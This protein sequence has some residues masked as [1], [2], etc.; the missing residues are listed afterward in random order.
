[1]ADVLVKLRIMPTGTDI[2]LNEVQKACETKIKSFGS[3]GMPSVK[4]EPIAFGL[5][6]LVFVFMI[7]EK[8]SN[9]EHLENNI[10]AIAGV[11]SAEVVDVRR[12]LG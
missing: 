11:A 3:K 8:I 7:D 12:A 10:K 1:M 9:M 4:Q 2:D 6:A 5:K